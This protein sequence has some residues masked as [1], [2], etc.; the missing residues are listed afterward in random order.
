MRLFIAGV[1]VLF[2]SLAFGIEVG[3]AALFLQRL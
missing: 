1:V 2:A 3:L